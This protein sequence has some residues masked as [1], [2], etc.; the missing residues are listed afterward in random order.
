MD[1]VVS[2]K[3]YVL[4]LIDYREQRTKVNQKIS[5]VFKNGV[6]DFLKIIITTP[7]ASWRIRGEVVDHKSIPELK[8]NVFCF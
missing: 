5:R 3:K 7:S 8:I 6:L 4:K 2:I 1:P